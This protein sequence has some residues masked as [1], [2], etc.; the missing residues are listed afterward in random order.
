MPTARLQS[1]YTEMVILMRKLYQDCRLIHGDLSEYNIL[2][3]EV[4][5]LSL[6]KKQGLIQLQISLEYTCDCERIELKGSMPSRIRV[7]AKAHF[8]LFLSHL[9]F[10]WVLI[11]SLPSYLHER[12]HCCTI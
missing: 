5:A 6:K 2:V 9:K 12:L 8:R 3:N 4:L 11:S 10:A 7:S 1:M